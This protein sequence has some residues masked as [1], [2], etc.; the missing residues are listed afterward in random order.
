MKFNYSQTALSLRYNYI[1]KRF[2]RGMYEVNIGSYIGYLHSA[3]RIIEEE[4]KSLTDN[5]TTIDYG[6][7]IGY[8][9]IIPFSKKLNFGTGV[10]AYYGLQNIYSGNEFIPAYMNKTNNASINISFSLKYR[11]K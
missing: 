1:S 7:F 8:E 10:K 3:Y 6:I 5:Y 11:F 2:I 4:K 9:Y